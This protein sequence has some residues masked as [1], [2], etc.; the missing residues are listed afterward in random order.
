[1]K[2]TLENLDYVFRCLAEV[3]YSG[4]T[5]NQQLICDAYDNGDL[6]I[7]QGGDNFKIKSVSQFVMDETKRIQERK[8]V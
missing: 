8:E 6:K 1:M 4:L 5:P 2:T 3:G 7:E